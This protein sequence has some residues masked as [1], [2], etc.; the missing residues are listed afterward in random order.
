MPTSSDYIE[1]IHVMQAIMDISSIGKRL[2]VNQIITGKFPDTL[3]KINQDELLDPSG[4]SYHYLNLSNIKGKARKDHKLTL[5]NSNY[6]LYS[7]GKDGRSA[8]PL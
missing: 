3:A 8:G 7:S 5:I 1:H 2:T 4:Y 6:D